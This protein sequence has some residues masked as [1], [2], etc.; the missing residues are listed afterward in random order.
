MS[1]SPSFFFSSSSALLCFFFPYSNLKTHFSLLLLFFFSLQIYRGRFPSRNSV[2]RA[3]RGYNPHLLRM[4]MYEVLTLSEQSW[5]C[6]L[7]EWLSCSTLAIDVEIW[8]PRFASFVV[9][10]TW[11]CAWSRIICRNTSMSFLFG[12]DPLDA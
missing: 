4:L 2:T 3:L 8:S 10:V 5:L 7:F 6:G 9:L 12:F 1:F 11:N